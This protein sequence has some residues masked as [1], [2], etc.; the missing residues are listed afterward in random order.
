[1]KLQA[2]YSNVVIGSGSLEEAK[3]QIINFMNLLYDVIVNDNGNLDPWCYNLKYEI[4]VAV[5]KE[6][7][8]KFYDV[9]RSLYALVDAIQINLKTSSD[10]S[11]RKL[12]EKI[13]NNLLNE[14]TKKFKLKYYKVQTIEFN[15]G[16]DK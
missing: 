4:K 9:N 12:C 7:L 3:F 14:L 2:N 1:M 15:Y 10:E 16:T 5:E 8:D 6:K 11:T 13:W